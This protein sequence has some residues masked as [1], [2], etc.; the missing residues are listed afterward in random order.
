MGRQSG[1]AIVIIALMLTVIIGMSAIAIDG[2]RAFALRRDLQAAVDAAALAAGDRLQQTGSYTSAEQAATSIFASNLRLYDTPTCP[3]GYLT[4]ISA[5]VQVTCNFADGTQ[6]KQV[7]TPLGPQG[8]QFSVTATRSLQLQFAAILTNGAKP[9]LYGAATGGVNNL[10]YTPAVAALDEAGCGPSGD[11]LTVD[12]SGT[13]SVTGDIVASGA[14]SVAF[15]GIRVAGDIYA[16][17]QS[18]VPGAV[19]LACYPSGASAPCSSPDVAGA[20]RPGYRLPDPNY[21]PPAVAGGLQ[22]AP[23]NDVVLAPGTYAFDPSVAAGRCY[24]LSGGVYRWN[25][26]YTSNGGFVSNEL[27]PPDEPNPTNNTLLA[28]TQFWNTNGVNCAGSFKLEATGGSGF[29][30]GTYG[31]ELTS[32]RSDTY[33]GTA[34]TRESAP[35]RCQ[36]INLLS[37]QVITLTVSNIPG[38]TSYNIYMSRTGCTPPFGLVYNLPVGGPVQNQNTSGCPFGSGSSCTLGQESVSAPT[39]VLAALPMPNAAA[40]PGAPGAYPPDG[41]AAP[42]QAGLPNLNP[43][44]A[45][46]PSGDRANENQCDTGGGALTTCPGPVTPGAV[47][48]YIPSG[49]CLNASST[50]DNFV[51]TGYQYNWVVLYE[52]GAANP[53]FNACT[54]TLSAAGNSAFIG[55]MYAPSAVV[56]V[57]GSYAFLSRGM[58]GLIADTIT[59]SGQ[60]PS[61]V[62]SPSY[63][64]RPPA[65]RLIG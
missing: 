40:A 21:P 46:A 55:L 12:G 43:P 10:L 59:F 8:S 19:A 16:H 44:R 58:G 25:S 1:Q 34:H 22:A 49:G 62:Y 61:I 18:T 11:A 29:L 47:A 51:F 4:P 9:S 63:A 56:N 48:F 38:A 65:S 37:G 39:W 6:L 24:F 28:G 26:G 5:A 23:G 54:N 17:C 3:T 30:P 42:L 33:A 15:G 35:S 14:I 64:P 20:T 2:S 45:T 52:P 60:L 7:V 31:F 36:T 27:K 32:I 53:P 13:L 57:Q 41:E 50:G